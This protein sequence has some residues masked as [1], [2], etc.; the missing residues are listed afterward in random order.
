MTKQLKEWSNNQWS[1]SLES[2]DL[3]DQSLWKTTRRVM[4]MPTPSPLL[5]PPGALALSDS[6][7]AEA[8]ADSLESQFHPANDPSVQAVIEEVNE[9][10]RAYSYASAS[11][12]Q[13]TNH[14][15]VQDAI[16]RFKVDKASCP[17]GI[18]NRDLKHLPLSVVSLLG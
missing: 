15:E 14:T 10:I 2:L 1:N 4:R 13:L 18:P 5:V 6:E 9:A 17:G 11:E 8:L 7:K 3:E 16:L 12:S